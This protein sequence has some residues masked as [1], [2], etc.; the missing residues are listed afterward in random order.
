MSDIDAELGP[1][2]YVVVAFPVG[3]A[4]FSGEMASSWR[5]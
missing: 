3:Q 1:V 2:D 5:L 4:D